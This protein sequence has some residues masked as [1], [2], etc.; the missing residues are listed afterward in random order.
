MKRTKK[1]KSRIDQAI[2]ETAKG[3]YDAGLLDEKSM[4]EFDASCLTPKVKKILEPMKTKKDEM[5]SDYSGVDLGKPVVGKHY[6]ACM[7]GIK[8]VLKQDTKRTGKG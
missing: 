1:Y 7:K 3:L 8:I 2:H 4:H 6:K 5:R